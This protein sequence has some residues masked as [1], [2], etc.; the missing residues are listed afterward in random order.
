MVDNRDIV[1]TVYY[2]SIVPE[3]IAS[4]IDRGD[5][6]S[7]IDRGDNTSIIDRGVIE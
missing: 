2:S 7:I 6:T 3:A 4:I 5:K 1:S